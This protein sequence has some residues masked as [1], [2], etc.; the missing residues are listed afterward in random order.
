MSFMERKQI[1]HNFFALLVAGKI[2]EAYERYVHHDF[3]H[4]NQYFRGDRESLKSAMKEAHKITSNKVFSI[5]MVLEEGNTVATFSHMQ[6]YAGHLGMAVTHWMR[7]EN[8]KIVEM[9]DM[10]QHIDANSPNEN[11]IF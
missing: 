4:H 1:I 10:G 2:H 7:F 6:P 5:K 9:W 8:G 3:I 11:G